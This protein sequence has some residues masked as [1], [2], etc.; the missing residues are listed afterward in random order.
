MPVPLPPVSCQ[1]V[2]ALPL[3]ED[4]LA[5][6]CQAASWSL[7]MLSARALESTWSP[8]SRQPSKQTAS[9]LLQE[10]L[11]WRGAC[12][13]CSAALQVGG[14]AGFLL[15][16]PSIF[17]VFCVTLRIPLLTFHFLWFRFMLKYKYTLEGKHVKLLSVFSHICVMC[18]CLILH[19]DAI[20]WFAETKPPLLTKPKCT[21]SPCS[22]FLTYALCTKGLSAFGERHQLLWPLT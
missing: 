10:F 3:Q 2:T 19:A 22:H 8:L 13:V 4:W 6:S 9:R 17:P 5:F 15:H 18:F 12:N 11:G 20:K 7:G 14:R 16:D 1:M 21:G